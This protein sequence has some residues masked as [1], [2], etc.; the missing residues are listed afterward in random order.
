MGQVGRNAPC[1]CGSGR[2]Y[3]KCCLGE[4]EPDPAPWAGDPPPRAGV[5]DRRLV[6]LLPELVNETVATTS[7]A[8]QGAQILVPLLEST[9]FDVTDCFEMGDPLLGL[10][11]SLWSHEQ[12]LGLP[13]AEVR[14]E[15]AAKLSKTARQLFEKLCE[16]G[17]R[18]IRRTPGRRPTITAE[19]PGPA[20]PFSEVDLVLALTRLAH[21]SASDVLGWTIQVNGVGILLVMTIVA[22]GYAPELK[23]AAKPEA[24]FRTRARAALDIDGALLADEL[25][26]AQCRREL[27]RHLAARAVRDLMSDERSIA[28]PIA[29]GE[30]QAAEA[31]AFARIDPMVEHWYGWEYDEAAGDICDGVLAQV[32]KQL[33]VDA[34]WRP[35]AFQRETLLTEPV[36]LLQLPAGHSLWEETA[37]TAPLRSVER[38]ADA[39]PGEHGDAALHALEG[40]C[41]ERRWLAVHALRDKPT[42]WICMR[43]LLSVADPTFLELPV[44]DLPLESVGDRNR[45]IA[46]LRWWHRDGTR[47]AFQIHDLLWKS[48]LTTAPGFGKTTDSRV[49]QALVTLLSTWRGATTV[50]VAK[51]LERKAA[52][53]EMAAGLAELADLFAPG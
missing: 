24:R 33:R 29:L 23:R 53:A 27:E 6:K 10:L 11:A 50:P 14:A 39:H 52:N 21:D 12:A 49:A 5:P 31:L 44:S 41:V 46:A 48:P 20:L 9:G 7:E 3:K 22:P 40:I 45:L 36:S 38:W 4:T 8:S 17:P 47:I 37:P 28:V 43:D 16:R 34:R 32:R 26:E 19:D 18:Y 15:I 2:K 42:V 13:L 35:R 51:P 30:A 1:P 25:Y